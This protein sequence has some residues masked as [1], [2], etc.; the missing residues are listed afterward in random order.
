MK[1]N[2]RSSNL[3]Q[4]RKSALKRLEEQFKSGVKPNKD[5]F[6]QGSPAKLPLTDADKHRIQKEILTL[7]ASIK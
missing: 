2:K 4:R 1:P 3:N 7:K 6:T 5:I